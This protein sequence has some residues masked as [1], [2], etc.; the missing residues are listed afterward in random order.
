MRSLENFEHT[1]DFCRAFF[2]HKTFKG[3][4]GGGCMVR[5]PLRA[6]LCAKDPWRSFYGRMAVK[7]SFIHRRTLTAL[8]YKEEVFYVQ[9]ADKSFSRGKCPLK[10]TYMTFKRPFL[11]SGALEAFQYTRDI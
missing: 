9:N 7:G 8:S 4:K 1:G 6:L 3:G 11:H 10:G 2:R 5:I